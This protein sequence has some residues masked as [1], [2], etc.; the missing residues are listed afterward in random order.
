MA[1]LYQIN[2]ILVGNQEVVMR[3]LRFH[4]QGVLLHHIIWNERPIDLKQ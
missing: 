3:C 4:F 2:C 1:N